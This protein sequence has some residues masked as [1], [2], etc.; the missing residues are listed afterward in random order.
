VIPWERRD[1]RAKVVAGLALATGVLLAPAPWVWGLAP[2][3]ALLAATALDR[4]RLLAL[5]RAVALLWVLTVLA[6]A[7]FGR[8]E[9]V[10]PESLGWFRPSGTGVRAGLAQGARL[11]ALAAVTAWMAAVTRALD[12]ASSLEWGVRDRPA[13]RRRV[14]AAVL[15]VVLGLRLV[16]ILAEEAARLAAVDR[17]RNRGARPGVRR[18]ASLAPVWIL[19]VMDR[20]DSLALAMTLRGYRPHVPR[21][22]ARAW[23]WDGGDWALA[24]A[25]FMGGVV[26]GMLP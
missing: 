19:A 24:L 14:H 26:L 22:F 23:R 7:A 3:G 9:R 13:L 5:A 11:A 17:L 8:G 1:P 2:A 4:P 16:P 20:A 18:L 6:N 15:P 12:L 25:G 10:G 21:G